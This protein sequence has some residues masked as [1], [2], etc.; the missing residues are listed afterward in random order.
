MNK[1]TFYYLLALYAF[2]VFTAQTLW[3]ALITLPVL[4]YVI[5]LLVWVYKYEN[6]D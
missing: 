5:K 6:K 1:F 2:A 3:I 4:F